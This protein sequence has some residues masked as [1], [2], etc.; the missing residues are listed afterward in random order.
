MVERRNQSQREPRFDT[1]PLRGVFYSFYFLA[2]SFP[3]SSDYVYS[4]ASNIYDYTQD[5]KFISR[6][7][8]A[9]SNGDSLW[10]LWDAQTL[11]GPDVHNFRYVRIQ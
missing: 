10:K 2:Q 7:Y 3:E 9:A 11:S 8:C 4:R 5:F 6:G 1:R